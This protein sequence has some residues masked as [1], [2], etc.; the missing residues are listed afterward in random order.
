MNNSKDKFEMLFG[1]VDWSIMHI[2][3]IFE[4]IESEIKDILIEGF[5]QTSASN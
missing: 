2:D 5:A 1:P 4:H 3:K